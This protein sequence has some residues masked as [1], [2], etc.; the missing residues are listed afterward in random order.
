[1][2]PNINEISTIRIG[3]PAGVLPVVA[4]MED[5]VVTKA[6]F[7]RTARKILE[8]QCFVETAKVCEK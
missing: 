7:Y 4:E 1:M 2:I 5:G 6:A 8:G 3:H